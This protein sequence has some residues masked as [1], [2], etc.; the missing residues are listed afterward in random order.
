MPCI[1]TSRYFDLLEQ[2][3]EDYGWE[4]KVGNI[5]NMDETG[6][7]LDLKPLKTIHCKGEK[8]PVA[9]GSGLKTQHYSCGVC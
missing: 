1:Y 7:P 9:T 8:K 2:T 6:M 3:I 5:F 4:R